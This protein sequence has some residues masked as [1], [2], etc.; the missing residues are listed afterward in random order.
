[1]TRSMSLVF[2]ERQ[3]RRLRHSGHCMTSF[4]RILRGLGL[5]TLGATVIGEVALHLIVPRS[6]GPRGTRPSPCSRARFTFF[7]MLRGVGA[8]LSLVML[9]RQQQLTIP[10]LQFIFLVISVGPFLVFD[11]ARAALVGFVLGG[12]I[13]QVVAIVL[14]ARVAGLRADYSRVTGLGG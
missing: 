5:I 9:L 8:T 10:V 7:M 11:T 13:F 1:M 4:M 14:Y 3:R 6:L 12:A 2:L